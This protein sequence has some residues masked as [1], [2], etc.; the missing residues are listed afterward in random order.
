M[1]VAEDSIEVLTSLN[2]LCCG[3]VCLVRILMLD[4]EKCPLFARPADR[5]VRTLTASTSHI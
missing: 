2:M 5:V 3:S 4:G 1:N